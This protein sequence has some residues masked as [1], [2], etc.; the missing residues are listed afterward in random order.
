VLEVLE[1]DVDVLLEVEVE[2]EVDVKLAFELAFKTAFELAF[3]L[4]PVGEELP[5]L[6]DIVIPV[7]GNICCIPMITFRFGYD[8][9]CCF[10]FCFFF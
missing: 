6:L 4:P 1:V 10:C 9:S 8:G 7:V 5:E 2:V 3:E